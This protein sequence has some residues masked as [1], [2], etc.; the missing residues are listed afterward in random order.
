MKENLKLLK[1]I[2]V[3]TLL[4]YNTSKDVVS[5]AMKYS[6]T[7]LKSKISKINNHKI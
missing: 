7:K 3:T 4:L 1:F 5:N 6:K 2:L